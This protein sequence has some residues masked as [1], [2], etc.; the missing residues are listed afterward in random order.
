MTKRAFGELELAI[1]QILRS[2]ERKSVKEV[3]LQLGGQDKYTTV[4]TVMNRLAEKKQIA[5]ERAGMH[6]EYW[7]L[8]SP[9]K[10]RSFLE[11]FKQK[12]LGYKTTAMVSYLIESA[13]DITQEDLVEME[14]MIEKAKEQRKKQ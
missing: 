6:Y 1:L 4:M 2:G 9:A 10:T 12:M 5:R 13:D 14:K 3:Q 11:Q 8:S 7:I